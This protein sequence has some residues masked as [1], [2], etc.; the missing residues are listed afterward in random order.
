M[1][2]TWWI[3]AFLRSVE[4]YNL[5]PCTIET[6]S[7]ASDLLSWLLLPFQCNDNKYKKWVRLKFNC[8]MIKATDTGL[9]YEMYPISKKVGLI[10]K[11]NTVLT[12]LLPRIIFSP[13]KSL[14]GYLIFS[15]RNS[16]GMGYRSHESTCI[17]F[18]QYSYDRPNN[19]I[20]VRVRLVGP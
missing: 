9:S 17:K 12:R 5:V 20:F 15:H 3:V 2:V 14:T 16:I 7:V 19:G 6:L 13:I 1:V 4:Y 11:Y 18:P 8:I 10:L